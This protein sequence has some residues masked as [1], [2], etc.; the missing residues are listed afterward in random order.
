MVPLGVVTSIVMGRFD[1]YVKHESGAD[2]FLIVPFYDMVA[3][4]ACLALAIAWRRKSELHRRLIFIA[5]CCLL[6][7]AFGR[8]DYIYDHGLFFWCL[9][10]VILLGVL[11]DLYVNRRIHKVYLTALPVLAVVQAFV[12]YTW[13]GSSGWWVRIAHGILG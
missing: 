4:G 13:M 9:D 10:G 3:F 5:T 2:A 12:T 1:T 6:D 7:A 8:S 11:R